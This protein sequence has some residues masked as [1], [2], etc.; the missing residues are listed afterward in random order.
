[1][2]VVYKVNMMFKYVA[3]ADKI[4]D[5]QFECKDLQDIASKVITSLE[6]YPVWKDKLNPSAKSYKVKYDE[7]Y[8]FQIEFSDNI[9]LAQ[10]FRE[11]L[12]NQLNTEFKYE[13]RNIINGVK[14]PRAVVWLNNNLT[15]CD[16][17]DSVM[18]ITVTCSVKEDIDENRN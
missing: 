11:D 15:L 1:M 14:E 13:S 4:T 18:K 2:K 5:T 17:E 7:G 3:M 6:E 8:G 12:I 10:S 16:E 9:N